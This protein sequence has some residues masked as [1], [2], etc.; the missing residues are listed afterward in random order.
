MALILLVAYA[1]FTNC[2]SFTGRAYLFRLFMERE[3]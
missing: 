1:V 3:G 2:D